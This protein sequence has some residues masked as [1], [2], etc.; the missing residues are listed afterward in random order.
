MCLPKTPSTPR[1]TIWIDGRAELEPQ[2][3]VGLDGRRRLRRWIADDSV[4]G[5][6]VDSVSRHVAKAQTG[7]GGPAIP[8]MQSAALWDRDHS[9]PCRRFNLTRHGRVAI[10][11]QMRP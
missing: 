6:Q 11:R 2:E 10:E 8:M 1:P 3:R 5:A 4:D 7:S 9:S